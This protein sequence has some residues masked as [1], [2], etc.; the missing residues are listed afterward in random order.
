MANV[1]QTPTSEN[2]GEARRD[3]EMFA[4]LQRGASRITVMLKDLTRNGARIEG[5]SGLSEDE[6]VSLALP[7]CKPKLA[8]VAWSNDHCAG[9][10]FSDPLRAGVFDAL[11]S[12]YAV[13]R[14]P[15]T[16][17]TEPPPSGA[18]AA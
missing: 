5:I 7:N 12:E 9:L 2:R 6:A 1:A 16:N 18:I 11:V 4:H 8:F 13:N 14:Q 17:G 10:E 3:V 15:E